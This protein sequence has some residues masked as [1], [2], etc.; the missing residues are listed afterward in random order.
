MPTAPP[1]RDDGYGSE[2]SPPTSSTSDRGVTRPHSVSPFMRSV[3]QRVEQKEEIDLEAVSCLLNFGTRDR[4]EPRPQT[5]GPQVTVSSFI[6]EETSGTEGG[7][8]S[9][10]SVMV[11]TFSTSPPTTPASA[12]RPDR[13]PPIISGRR[14]SGHLIRPRPLR[15]SL[16]EQERELRGMCHSCHTCPRSGSVPS[17]ALGAPPR[18][19]EEE[20]DNDNDESLDLPDLPEAPASPATS[21]IT[22]IRLVEFFFFLEKIIFVKKNI[23]FLCYL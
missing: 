8:T 7:G 23:V 14:Q 13:P 4:R 6:I 1:P 21:D 17:A 3:R 11:R 19:E 22:V 15:R 18:Q 10:T 16:E 2:G 9:A 5:P 20:G 12:P